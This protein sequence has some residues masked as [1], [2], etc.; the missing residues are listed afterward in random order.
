MHTLS[1]QNN[2][3]SYSRGRILRVM[4]DAAS[5]FELWLL[6]PSVC[7]ARLARLALK[8]RM[9]TKGKRNNSGA[10]LLG[11]YTCHTD[12]AVKPVGQLKHL[13]GILFTG[14]ISVI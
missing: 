1:A 8:L 11:K 10:Q 7:L 2:N 9:Q 6:L 14:S 13:V 5:F 12:T 3:D 4:G